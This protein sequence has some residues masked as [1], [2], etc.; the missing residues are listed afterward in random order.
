MGSEKTVFR[1]SSVGS[2]P[3]LLSL[4]LLGA[5]MEVPSR[6]EQTMLDKG[7]AQEAAAIDYLERKCDANVSARDPMGKQMKVVWEFGDVAVVGHI[8]GIVEYARS[9]E[10]TSENCGGTHL[11]E[12]KAMS[13]ERFEIFGEEGLASFPAYEA[14]IVAY[15]EGLRAQDMWLDGVTV[16]AKLWE[17]DKYCVRWWGLEEARD[18]MEPIR[19]EL[20]G[21]LSEIA[22]MARE[23]NVCETQE[24]GEFGCKKCAARFHCFP[25]W[26]PQSA[27][28]D[29][30]AAKLVL[31]YIELGDRMK[32]AQEER[33]EVSKALD[34][35]LTEAGT[36]TLV[37]PQA[38]V[39]R[40]EKV[41]RRK[42]EEFP[43]ALAGEV[44]G[45][46]EENTSTSI[47]VTE[48]KKNESVGEPK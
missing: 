10:Q 36:V 5:E 47:R 48:H 12:I 1:A 34:A 43:R 39:Q 28:A 3:K 9:A 19:D 32:Q 29:S 8:D 7:T 2:C 45:Y 42:V 35:E 46:Y 16:V 14:Q 44:V 27:G 6:S 21:K 40:I 33:E 30:E 11:L 31:R 22:D 26:L 17:Q 41:T 13:A 20:D 37:L 38:T 23:G 15:W 24:P 4:R 18:W 25:E